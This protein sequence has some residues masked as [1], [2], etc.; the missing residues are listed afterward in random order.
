MSIKCYLCRYIHTFCVVPYLNMVKRYY[1]K[2]ALE[3]LNFNNFY[4]FYKVLNTDILFW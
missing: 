1:S 2:I 4:I 3:I